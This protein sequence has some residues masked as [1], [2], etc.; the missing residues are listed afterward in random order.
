MLRGMALR[1]DAGDIAPD[2][3]VPVAVIAG[4][5][6]AALP[7]VQAQAI[8]AAFPNGRLVPCEH[9]GHVP[10]LEEPDRVTEALEALLNG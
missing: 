6:D 7:L 9:S 1:D 8:A 4:V 10:M 5:A 2:L 3:D